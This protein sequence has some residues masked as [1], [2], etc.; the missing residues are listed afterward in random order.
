VILRW[1]P[2]L[3]PAAADVAAI[4]ATGVLQLL[5]LALQPPTILPVALL[6]AGLQTAA[7][8]WRRRWPLP[9][10]A[11]VTGAWAFGAAAGVNLAGA[12]VAVPVAVYAVGSR[13]GR[14]RWVVFGLAVAWLIAS[15]V[16]SVLSPAHQ[17]RVVG[18]AVT[19]R[20]V[21]ELQVT[22]TGVAVVA[23]F[24][25]G[26][27]TRTRRAYLAELETRLARQEQDREED[28]RRAA[29]QERLR[30][31]RELHDVVAHHVSAIAVEAAAERA[32]RRDDAGAEAMNRIAAT[33]RLALSELNQLLGVLRRETEGPPP[34]APGPGLDQAADLVA[35]ARAAGQDV[36]LTVSGTARPLPAALDLSA[37]R[38]VQE[39][40]TN[41]RRHAAG[42]H[43]EVRIRHADDGLEIRVTDDG[44]GTAGAIDG[45]GHGLSG[46]RE[47][48]E[49]FGG[50]FDAGPLPAGGFLVSAHLPIEPLP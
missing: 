17:I 14:A 47:R 45:G 1:P 6:A 9:V 7:L 19:E 25:M 15:A 44:P 36:R 21:R 49:V 32:A 27:I 20:D 38:I 13:S 24:L 39:A 23:V 12:I 35:Q 31:A 43:V 42:A 41:A 34:R 5:S 30:I 40:I 37:Y 2:R 11:V 16:Q 18:T 4:G 10:L 50:R 48:V 3:S 28:R 46:M 8:R 22:W 29:E 26:E 33:A